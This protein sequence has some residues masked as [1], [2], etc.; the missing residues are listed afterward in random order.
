[1]KVNEF[2]AQLKIAC[3][4]GVSKHVKVLFWFGCGIATRNCQAVYIFR[5]LYAG[6]VVVGLKIHVIAQA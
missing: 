4:L 1:M 3:R 5:E 2:D 6:R